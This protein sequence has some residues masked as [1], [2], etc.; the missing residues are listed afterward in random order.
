L[1]LIVNGWTLLYHPVFGNRYAELR[2]EARRLKGR[3]PEAEYRAHPLVKLGAA[4]RRLV[5]ETVSADPDHPDFRLSGDLSA[6]RRAK[7][8]GLPPR[9]RLFWAFSRQARTVIFLYLN[10]SETLRK[11]GAK[12]DPY[13][14]FRHLVVRGD[15]GD[16]FAANLAAWRRSHDE[17]A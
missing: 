8:H 14:V 7:G 1:P 5:M 13:E 3:L 12:T 16:D 4:V 15:I 6:F 2:E 10:T 17:G 9:Y 11:E